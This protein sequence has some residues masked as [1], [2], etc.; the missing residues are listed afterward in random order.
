MAASYEGEA[1][2][3]FLA[4]VD[5]AEDHYLAERFSVSAVPTFLL[6]RNRKVKNCAVCGFLLNVKPSLCVSSTTE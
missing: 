4:V 1:L 6:F 2:P 3:V 5:I